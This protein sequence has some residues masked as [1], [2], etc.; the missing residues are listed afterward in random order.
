MRPIDAEAITDKLKSLF[1]MVADGVNN[2]IDNAPTLD[3][4][5][6]VHGKWQ[7]NFSRPN[8]FADLF[9][10]CSNC[11]YKASYTYADI[12]YNYCPNCGADMRV[13]GDKE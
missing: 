9:W 7:R 13:V 6:V 4:K 11:G 1:P 8:V 5:P 2:I 10:H 3:V 12:Y